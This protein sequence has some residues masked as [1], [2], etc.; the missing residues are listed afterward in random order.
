MFCSRKPR[1]VFFFGEHAG[2]IGP[3]PYGPDKNFFGKIGE[4]ILASNP[5]QR[6]IIVPEFFATL[7]P[8]SP[9]NAF[10][11]MKDHLS[12][13]DDVVYD[14]FTSKV[15]AGIAPNVHRDWFDWGYLDAVLDKNSH[16]PGSVLVAPE[17]LSLSANWLY[18]LARNR[19]SNPVS[20]LKLSAAIAYE[21]DVD[22]RT[23]IFQLVSDNP[24]AQIYIPRGYA[25]LPMHEFFDRAL[26]DVEVYSHMR[27]APRP[28]TDVIHEYY[29]GPVCESQWR[30]YAF[31]QKRYLAYLTELL[32]KYVA[33]GCVSGSFD[34]AEFRKISDEAKQLAYSASLPSNLEIY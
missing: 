30:A 18:F 28:S 5:S 14:G 11:Q 17:K 23:Q 9:S 20:D 13:V 2:A 33:L 27:G 6:Q 26:F 22:L 12:A 19:P 25:H 29:A 15:N 8:S 32:P 3:V 4:R 21:R 7:T 31:Y 34:E 10:G 16:S 24:G 1:L